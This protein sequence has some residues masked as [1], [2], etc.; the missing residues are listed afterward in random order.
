[1]VRQ[2]GSA[3]RVLRWLRIVGAA[4]C[5]FIA[6]A[7]HSAT[8][9]AAVSDCQLRWVRREEARTKSRRR[10]GLLAKKAPMMAL[11]MAGPAPAELTA[12]L[13]GGKP[14]QSLMQAR[15]VARPTPPGRPANHQ[16]SFQ[17]K[18]R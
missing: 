8:A 5:E 14:S 4:R 12:D 9:S 7:A 11:R 13:V 2:A 18:A 15:A 1:M 10:S 6:K 3:Q 17:A 16:R